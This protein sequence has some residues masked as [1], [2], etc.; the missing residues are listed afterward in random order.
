MCPCHY[1]HWNQGFNHDQFQV[2]LSRNKVQIL[3]KLLVNHLVIAYFNCFKLMILST[4]HFTSLNPYLG[5]LHYFDL[6]EI[7]FI[8]SQL[9]WIQQIG[10]VSLKYQSNL[11][12]PYHKRKCVKLVSWNFAITLD[13][14]DSW[15][16]ITHRNLPSKNDNTSLGRKFLSWLNILLFS[17]AN[18]LAACHD[19]LSKISRSTNTEYQK[20]IYSI[21]IQFYHWREQFHHMMICSKWVYFAGQDEKTFRTVRFSASDRISADTTLVSDHHINHSSEYL[22]TFLLSFRVLK[23]IFWFL[24]N[25]QL[26]LT[27]FTELD[28]A[29]MTSRIT[30]GDTM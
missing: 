18:L 26:T 30:K 25:V 23:S 3:L 16:L 8:A 28:Y 13:P 9:V 1:F 2:S 21:A 4:N 20:S 10:V 7:N 24:H 11:S 15:N 14:R 19:T 27:V 5:K 12:T 17:W 29:V 22:M 6:V